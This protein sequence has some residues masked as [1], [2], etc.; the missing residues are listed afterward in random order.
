[1]KN[2]LHWAITIILFGG[3]VTNV[4]AQKKWTQ[5][6]YAQWEQIALIN[7]VKFTDPQYN[8]S[9]AGSAFLL[10]TGKE[11]VACTAKHVL[12]LAKSKA[13]NS[14][15]FRGTLKKWLFHPK[16]DSS[17]PII[18]DRLLN[19]DINEKLDGKIM[20]K[21]CIVFTLKTK[22]RHIQTL[23]LRKTPIRANETVYVIGCPYVDKDCVQNVYKGKFVKRQGHN[24]LVRL[25]NR[26]INLGGM[27]GGA[28][29]DT[30]GEVVG[31]VSR[32]IREAK[33]KELFLG[34]VSTEYLKEIL[35]KHKKM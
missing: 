21:D 6:P 31:I 29:I 25:E 16:G 32:M 27:S 34:P 20:A 9:Y 12:F 23:R 10:D 8:N 3:I 28:V 26:K 33:T 2:L 4:S 13:M 35:R 11:V 30:N 5:K 22:P 19:T 24:L 7:H 15:H 1:M 18:A 14:V 17:K